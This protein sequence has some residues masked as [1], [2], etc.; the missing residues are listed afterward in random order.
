MERAKMHHIRCTNTRS[1]L[2]AAAILNAS[3]HL[4]VSTLA[5]EDGALGMM[6]D[7]FADIAV[8][9]A[10]IIDIRDENMS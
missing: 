2:V 5:R 9:K 8:A 3:S 10:R 7:N 6:G 4:Q 1:L